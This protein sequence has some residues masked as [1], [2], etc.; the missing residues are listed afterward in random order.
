[1]LLDNA[2]PWAMMDAL[3]Q[4]TT[5]YTLSVVYTDWNANNVQ[6]FIDTSGISVLIIPRDIGQVLM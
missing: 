3:A 1:M 2:S 5:D 4:Y 6:T